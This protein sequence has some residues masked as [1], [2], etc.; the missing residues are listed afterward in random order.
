MRLIL[1][2]I[3]FEFDLTLADESKDWLKR[4]RP[5]TVW[6]KPPLMIH[7]SPAKRG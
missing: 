4:S 1:A 5:F 3:I 2:R 7:L 6:E